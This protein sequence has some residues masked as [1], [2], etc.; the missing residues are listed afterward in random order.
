MIIKK[1]IAPVIIVM[2]C[3]SLVIFWFHKGLL[4][5]GGEESLMFY[6][7]QKSYSLFNSVWYSTDAGYQSIVNL[8]RIPFFRFLSFASDF[9]LS[10][11]QLQAFTFFMLLSTGALSVYFLIRETVVEDL[12]LAR[13]DWLPFLSA[14]FYILNPFSLSQIWGRGLT[15]QF[16]SF[17]LVPLFLVLFIQGLKTKNILFGLAAVLASFFFSAAY[18]HPAIVLVSWFNVLLYFLFYLIRNKKKQEIIFFS[19]FY[20]FIIISFWILTHSFWIFPTWQLGNQLLE[21]STKNDGVAVLQGVSIHTPLQTV[22]RLL[23]EGVFY[24]DQIYGKV[25][26]TMSF[27]ALSWFIPMISLFSISAFKRCKDSRF[28]ITLFL[29][30]LF[31]SIGSNFPTGGLL[32]LLFKIFPLL[33]VLRNPYEKFG[34]NLLLAYIPFF[35]IGLLVLSGKI[36]DKIKVNFFIPLISIMLIL[37]CVVFVWPLWNGSFAGGIFFN[38]W[39]KVP[40]Y[41]QE[42]D[43]WLRTQAGDFKI[44]QVPL[45]PGDGIRYT[46]EHRFQGIEPGEYIFNKTSVGRDIYTNRNHYAILLE[47][48][49]KTKVGAYLPGRANDYEDFKGGSLTDELAKLDI[50][51][52]ILHHDVDW[53]FN[54]SVSPE[55]T[56]LY[57]QNQPGISKYLSFGKLDIYKV[58]IPENIDLIYS[59]DINLTYKKID[60]TRYQ[61]DIKNAKNSFKVYFLEQFDPLWEAYINDEKIENHSKI[62]SYANSWFVDKKGDYSILIKYKPQQSL[63]TGFKSTTVSLALMAIVAVILLFRTKYQ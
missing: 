21:S 8:A 36:T 32:I 17:A 24:I 14:I 38:P 4:F 22:L 5:A 31:L 16:F 56:E 39:V 47:R 18:A 25:Y 63:E 10:S 44:L 29:I 58:D 6:D 55:E 46:W 62:F 49:G 43:S 34:I 30:A 27:L 7:V 40:A 53:E 13:K 1:L 20:L 33:Q 15:F 48:F 60:N 26:I 11:V 12:E 50:R 9:G 2:L 23:H 51:Y 41:Y 52:I 59:P 35:T 42:A 3:L 19:I 61:I 28:Y 57:L 45:I 54:G 37:I